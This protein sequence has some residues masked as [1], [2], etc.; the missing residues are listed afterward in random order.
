[1]ITT[2]LIQNELQEMKRIHSR[3]QKRSASLTCRSLHTRFEHGK[4]RPY[5]QTG[6]PKYISRKDTSCFKNII[7]AKALQQLQ[8]R[9]AHNIT[10]LEQLSHGYTSLP[11]LFSTELTAP[12]IQDIRADFTNDAGEIQNRTGT[13]LPSTENCIFHYSAMQ[14]MQRSDAGSQNLTIQTLS[15]QNN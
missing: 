1:M 14:Q 2:T 7:Q 3:C 4:P 9:I 10:L 5:Y 11:E 6:K 13:E 12:I 8:P 15:I